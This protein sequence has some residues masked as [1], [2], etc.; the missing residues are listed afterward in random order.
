MNQET[1]TPP[2]TPVAPQETPSTPKRKAR[3]RET[4]SAGKMGA[5]VLA[6]QGDQESDE[7][8]GGHREDRRVLLSLTHGRI[9]AEKKRRSIMRRDVLRLV[10]FAVV[11]C[12]LAASGELAAAP[13]PATIVPKVDVEKV[14]GGKFKVESPEPG[15]LFY[16]EDG[17][18]S[19]SVQIYLSEAHG[20]L[21]DL[22]AQ[23]EQDKEP[24]EDV[25]GI[26]EAALYRPQRS[27]ATVEKTTESGVRLQLS[28]AVQNAASAADAKRFA[29][30]L[31][32]RAATKL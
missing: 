8:H 12:A 1:L 23:L 14:L 5:V 17:T 4:T 15:V 28:V 25:A 6:H 21:S 9:S 32:R 20:R 16:T 22:K 11:V 2:S 7:E 24:V 26:G 30:E 29:V 10:A 13:D 31:L 19:R 3:K 27:E 18:G